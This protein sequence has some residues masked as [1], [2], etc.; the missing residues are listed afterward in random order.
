[1]DYSKYQI[2]EVGDFAMNHMDLLTGFVDISKNEG[3]TSPDYRVFTLEDR[4]AFPNYYLYFL[5]I[6]YTNK[7]FFPFGQGA[8]HLGRWRLPAEAFNNFLAPYPPR[9]EQQIIASFL[10]RETAKIDALISEQ[11]RLIELLKE[12]RQ[13]VISHAVTKG[14]NPDAPMKDSGVEWLGKVPEHWEVKRLRFVAKL[15]PSK[16]ETAQLYKEREVSFLPMEV[17]GDD[18][19]LNLENTRSI[20]DVKA[21]YTYFREGDI[22][23]AKITPCF[24]NGKGAIMR[25]LLGGIGFGTTELIVAR[26]IISAST[27]NY[28]YWL[29]ITTPFRKLGEA[30]M[31]G[32]GGQKRVP[33][34]FVRN[35]TIGLPPI[36]EQQVIATF[37]DNQ[38]AKLD[39]L[40]TQVQRAINLLQ[41]RRSALITAAVTGQIDVTTWSKKG[42]T[43]IHLDQIEEASSA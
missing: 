43:D 38:T 2:V 27:R 5:Q 21:G 40:T 7:L 33:D 17:I 19:S 18:G 14:L 29:F 39:T 41:E 36:V 3:V 28:L 24:E 34:D 1:M 32:A 15:N 35:F 16:S 9:T 11:Q 8:A 25:G 37:L 6:G 13:S 20:V 42:K 22:T 26:P 31:Y 12:K 4:N 30:S 10:D 23:I